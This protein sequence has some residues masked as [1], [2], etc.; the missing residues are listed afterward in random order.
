M[1]GTLVGGNIQAVPLRINGELLFDGS[2]LLTALHSNQQL[3][4]YHVANNTARLIGSS[5]GLGK[6]DSGFAVALNNGTVV[7]FVSQADNVS[8]SSG[9]TCKVYTYA[10]AN[11]VPANPGAGGSGVDSA[12]RT[13][14]AT[15]QVLLNEAS[16]IP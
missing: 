15:I 9:S 12:L 13:K 4:V 5:N 11:A 14:V 10:F 7:L 16:L 1:P 3:S 6:V 8:G 2:V